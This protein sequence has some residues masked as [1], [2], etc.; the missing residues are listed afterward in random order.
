MIYGKKSENS[1]GEMCP[2]FARVALNGESEMSRKFC[3]N[4]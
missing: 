3:S 2:Q 1:S 4:H